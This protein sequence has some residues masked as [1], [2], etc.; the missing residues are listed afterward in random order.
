MVCR[1]LGCWAA[2]HTSSGEGTGKFYKVNCSGGETFLKECKF[3]NDTCDSKAASVICSGEKTSGP[4][5]SFLVFFHSCV[6]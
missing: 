3:E 1:E 2:P 5:V 4:N 6:S